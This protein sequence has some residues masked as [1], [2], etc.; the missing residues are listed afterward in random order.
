LLARERHFLVVGLHRLLKIISDFS[1]SWGTGPPAV[2]TLDPD[3]RRT[4]LNVD[5]MTTQWGIPEDAN[6]RVFSVDAVL[7]QVLLL[8]PFG[9]VFQPVTG[10]DPVAEEL[11]DQ[12]WFVDD[13]HGMD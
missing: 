2:I 5:Q 3:R 11:T 10:A 6:Q 12:A 4:S 13:L 9:P 8:S 1:I 7:G